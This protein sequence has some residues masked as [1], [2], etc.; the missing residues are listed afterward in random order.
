MIC[1]QIGA[2]GE[3]YFW[4]QRMSRSEV[5]SVYAAVLTPYPRRLSTTYLVCYNHFCHSL[6]LIISLFVLHIFLATSC[7]FFLKST[8]IIFFLLSVLTYMR[9]VSLGHQLESR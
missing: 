9:I 4:W 2:M 3:Y 1:I 7:S 6:R 8:Y 5:C